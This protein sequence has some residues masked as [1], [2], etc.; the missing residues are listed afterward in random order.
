[1]GF[2]D[3]DY[4]REWWAKKQG[5]VER[6]RMRMPLGLPVSRWGEPQRKGWH[7]VLTGLATVAVCLCVWGVVRFVAWRL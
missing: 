3:R 4:Y 7:P 1:M 5:F 2:Q 6:S